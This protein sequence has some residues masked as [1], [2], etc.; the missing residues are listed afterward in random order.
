MAEQADLVSKRFVRPLEW[1]LKMRLGCADDAYPF[2]RL[3]PR[4]SKG[5]YASRV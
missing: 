3:V 5:A 4:C 2:D 1:L